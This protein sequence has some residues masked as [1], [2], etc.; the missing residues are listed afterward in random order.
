[1]IGNLP[2]LLTGGA[3]ASNIA[4]VNPV[5]NLAGGNTLTIAPGAAVISIS[6]SAQVR[7]GL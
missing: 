2:V 5:L 4:L 1:M 3:T 6:G 7:Q